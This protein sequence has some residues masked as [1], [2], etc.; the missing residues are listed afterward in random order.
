MLTAGYIFLFN[1]CSIIR[2]LKTMITQIG[3]LHF[4]T[5]CVKRGKDIMDNLVRTVL[6]IC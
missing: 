1:Y 3:F 4:P 5:F 6:N 2:N